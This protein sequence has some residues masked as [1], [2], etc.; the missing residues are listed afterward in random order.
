MH[1]SMRELL[2]C[3]LSASES[4][5]KAVCTARAVISGNSGLNAPLKMPPLMGKSLIFVRPCSTNSLKTFRYASAN[6]STASASF[7][8]CGLRK[9]G[10]T[11]WMH[12]FV[13]PA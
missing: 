1:I 9:S 4:S 12:F 6:F 3:C 2:M 13:P 8:T 10:P 7:F 5:S 11:T